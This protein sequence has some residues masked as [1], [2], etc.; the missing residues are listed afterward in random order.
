MMN[1]KNS[2]PNSRYW[3]L[4][5]L[6]ENFGPG[7]KLQGTAIAGPEVAGQAFI[8]SRGKKL[9]LINKRNKEIQVEL[10]ADAKNA[11]VNYVNATTGDNP[12][13]QS[14]LDNNTITLKP[15][16]VAVVNF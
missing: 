8:T 3:V 6:K 13:A 14:Q 9:L 1:W 10:P 7:D 15:F 4:K 12:I 16:E 11:K 2:K 5:L